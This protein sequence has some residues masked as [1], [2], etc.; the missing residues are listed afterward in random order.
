MPACAIHA[1][2]VADLEL[3]DLKK[4]P[5]MWEVKNRKKLDHCDDFKKKGD[6]RFK[7]GDYLRAIRRYDRARA[8]RKTAAFS[9]PS[10]GR[11][12]DGAAATPPRRRRDAA[13]TRIPAPGAEEVAKSDTY[14]TDDELAELRSKRPKILRNR[15]AAHLKVRNYLEA[16]ND[17]RVALQQDPHDKKALFRHG[18]ASLKLDELDAAR[19]SLTKLLVLD[20]DK[21][22]AKKD[23]E[24]VDEK[25]RAAAAKTKEI[26][27]G[28]L[29]SKE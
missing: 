3:F 18:H 22:R 14:M 16:R 6:A 7:A 12:F 11:T 15:S 5:E 8:A 13:A 25:A 26:F 17:A 10:E 20:P 21:K 4:L 19:M 24:Q 28:Y 9:S 29:D 23:L 2:L 1:D 27:K